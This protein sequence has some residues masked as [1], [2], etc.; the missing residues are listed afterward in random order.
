MR[1][2]VL[3]FILSNGGRA[4]IGDLRE[5]VG[6]LTGSEKSLASSLRRYVREGLLEFD[7][8]GY[9]VITDLG[10]KYLEVCIGKKLKA[11]RVR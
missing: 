7:D 2:G 11:I 1:L 4:R 8:L 5:L 9:Y 6:V 10:L 3:S